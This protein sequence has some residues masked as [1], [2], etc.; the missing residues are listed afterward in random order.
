M[1]QFYILLLI[2]IAISVKGSPVSTSI[3]LTELIHANVSNLAYQNSSLNTFD[4]LVYANTN[5]NASD[6]ELEALI[7][8]KEVDPQ[9]AI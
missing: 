7:K 6:P 5:A 3:S 2:T 4:P 1:M 8:K 9:M